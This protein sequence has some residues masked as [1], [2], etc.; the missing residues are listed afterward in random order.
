MQNLA[1][2]IGEDLMKKL[3]TGI[4]LLAA[5]CVLSV[6]GIYAQRYTFVRPVEFVVPAQQSNGSGVAPDETRHVVEIYGAK[7]RCPRTRRALKLFKD[8]GAEIKY[9][10]IDA[11]TEADKIVEGNGRWLAN[12]DLPFI[13]IDGKPIYASDRGMTKALKLIKSQ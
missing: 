13:K 12:G 4:V 2:V 5:M 11:D 9:F 10:D 3:T 8:A 7:R 6:S 1:G